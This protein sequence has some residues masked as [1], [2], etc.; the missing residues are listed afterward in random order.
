MAA[1]WLLMLTP[2]LTALYG[3]LYSH[4]GS[5]GYAATDLAADEWGGVGLDKLRGGGAW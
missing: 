3:T 5:G 4:D 2:A 1:M